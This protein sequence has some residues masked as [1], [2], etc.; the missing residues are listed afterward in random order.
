MRTY[1]QT[2]TLY[3]MPSEPVP[4]LQNN[5]LTILLIAVTP[6]ALVIGLFIYI[7]KKNSKKKKN[8]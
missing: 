6:I 1:A 3:G 2:Q 8:A 4:K 5:V 7:T